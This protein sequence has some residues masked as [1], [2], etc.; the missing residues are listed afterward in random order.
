MIFQPSPTAW[1]GSGEHFKPRSRD[2]WDNLIDIKTEAH[3]HVIKIDNHM[4]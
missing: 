3:Y 2:P 1:C 4:F